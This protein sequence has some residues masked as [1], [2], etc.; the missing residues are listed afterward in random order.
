[1]GS[2]Y[3]YFIP[4]STEGTYKSIKIVNPFSSFKKKNVFHLKWNSQSKN[5]IF[6]VPFFSSY[7]HPNG[8]GNDNGNTT[9]EEEKKNEEIKFHPKDSLMFIV[10][11]KFKCCSI[12]HT[13]KF[14]PCSC[15]ND[16]EEEMKRVRKTKHF[17]SAIFHILRVALFR[18][19]RKPN[20]T[21]YSVL[22]IISLAW[23]VMY[24]MDSQY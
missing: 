5:I 21:S 15:A 18:Y 13:M 9:K 17:F 7:F 24:L 6:T 8:H 19:H 3:K 22:N 4:W 16:E 23:I 20:F 1:M 10:L 14:S 12:L 2:I 11:C